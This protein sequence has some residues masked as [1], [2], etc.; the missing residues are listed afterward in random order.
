MSISMDASVNAM[1][2]QS[3]AMSQN[4]VSAVAQ[5]KLLKSATMSQEAAVLTL[6]SSA[7]GL[8]TYDA[9]GA[10][11]SVPALGQHINVTA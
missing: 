8:Q 2:G 9:S 4:Q 1:V 11:Q 10:M 3:M 5:V 7:A 6:L